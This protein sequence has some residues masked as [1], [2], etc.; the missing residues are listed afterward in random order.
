MLA[1][2]EFTLGVLIWCGTLWD[3][4]ATIVLP[5][6]VSPM[7][8]L[9]GRFN[10]RSWQ[11]WAVLGRRI[12]DQEQRL[13]FLAV[14]GPISV[15]LLLILWAWLI[16]FAWALVYHSL[17]PSVQGA[18]GRL[19]FGALLYA[20]A[21]TFL[22]LGMGDVTAANAI[23]RSCLLLE[24]ASG[25][26]FLALVIT[27]MPVLEQAYG[28][29]EVDNVLILSRA[30]RPPNVLRL[31]HRYSTPDRAEILR[32]Y[33]HEA[34]RWMAEILQTHLSHP[35]LSFYRA[36]HWGQS[37]LISLTVVLDGCAL[38]M[39]SGTGLSAAQARLTYRMGLGLLKDLTEALGITIDPR[40]RTRLTAS[41]LPTFLAASEALRLN[42]NLEP[43]ACEALL[44]LVR[45]YDVYLLA[46]SEWLVIPL[47]SW[48]PPPPAGDEPD[49]CTE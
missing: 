4:F 31:L 24:A 2:L 41:E 18:N 20:S 45:R 35:V 6:T 17:G 38:L 3:G 10:R 13:S 44:R 8:R 29:R 48:T 12:R 25:Y 28:A 32:G 49:G 1:G 7:R 40:V 14:Y 5:R 27:Y 23:G 19:S 39:V 37:W 30:G 11:V 16:I 15:M 42:L 43:A 33:L 34:E 21:S 46:L 36:Q 9:S 26:L 22:T 47:P